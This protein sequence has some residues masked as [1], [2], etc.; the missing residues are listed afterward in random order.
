[1]EQPPSSGNPYDYVPAGVNYPGTSGVAVAWD[2][3]R[4][5]WGRVVNE[6]WVDM[7]NVQNMGVILV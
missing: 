1:M 5:F 4:L 3:T 7:N 2:V 6:A